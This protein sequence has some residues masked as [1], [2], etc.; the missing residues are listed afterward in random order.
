VLTPTITTDKMKT[1][2]A[3]LDVIPLLKTDFY[4]KNY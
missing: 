1:I 3:L 2:F 4:I